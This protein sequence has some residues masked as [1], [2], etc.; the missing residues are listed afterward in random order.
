M[1]KLCIA[2]LLSIS[3]IGVSC[4]NSDTDQKVEQTNSNISG[5][6]Y[7]CPMHPEIKSDKPGQCPKCNMDLEE[8]NSPATEDTTKK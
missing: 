5:K 3:L 4:G 8:V 6:V 2:L 1:K 7:T